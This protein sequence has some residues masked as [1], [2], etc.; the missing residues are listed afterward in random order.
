MDCVTMAV[1]DTGSWRPSQLFSSA[2]LMNTPIMLVRT[3]ADVIAYLSGGSLFLPR[4]LP[5]LRDNAGAVH[6][7]YLNGARAGAPWPGTE[8]RVAP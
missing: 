7:C 6:R 2:I 3:I 1:C 4:A 8:P 5:A